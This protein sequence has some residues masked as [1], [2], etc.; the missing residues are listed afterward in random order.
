MELAVVDSVGK[1]LAVVDSE[2]VPVRLVVCEAL[3]VT[4]GERVNDWLR[5]P[6]RLGLW[7]PV[8]ERVRDWDVDCERDWVIV[9][10]GLR[11]S[12]DVKLRD[13]ETLAVPDALADTDC[14]AEPDAVADWVCERLALADRVR[15]TLGVRDALGVTDRV[16]PEVTDGV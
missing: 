2:M 16:S 9:R 5:V 6:V 15:V 7:V 8:D 11:V 13:G 1:A 10:V 4:L 3:L 12:D 14:E